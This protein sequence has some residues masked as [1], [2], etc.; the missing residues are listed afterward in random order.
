MREFE[1]RALFNLL[2]VIFSAFM[3]REKRKFRHKTPAIFLTGHLIF[4]SISRLINYFL[5][6]SPISVGNSHL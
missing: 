2:Q 5:L 4:P 3:W 6:H 1:E